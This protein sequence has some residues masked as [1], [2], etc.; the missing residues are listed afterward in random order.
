[1]VPRGLAADVGIDPVPSSTFE[2][3]A[4]RPHFSVLD[5]RWAESKGITMPSWKGALSRYLAS[6]D[7]P[8]EPVVPAEDPAAAP[9]FAAAP[10]TAA[11]PDPKETPR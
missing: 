4:R 3:A 11:A 10:E 2:T 5:C 9:D 6:D 7:C 8:Y 1:M